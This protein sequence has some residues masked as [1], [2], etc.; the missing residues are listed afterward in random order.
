[1]KW[2][3]HEDDEYP[4]TVLS[5]LKAIPEKSAQLERLVVIDGGSEPLSSWSSPTELANLLVEFTSKL[6]HLTCCCLTFKQLS[7]DLMKE[8][9]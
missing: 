3:Q 9:N 1:M 6:N 7:A 4:E 5:I 8:I 2:N